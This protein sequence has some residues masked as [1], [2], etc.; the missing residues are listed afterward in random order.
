MKKTIELTGQIFQTL[1][2]LA[3]YCS[4]QS[5]WKDYLDQLKDNV[6]L[7]SFGLSEEAADEWESFSDIPEEIRA[8]A[9]Q[10]IFYHAIKAHQFLEEVNL[11]QHK[12]AKL[13]GDPICLS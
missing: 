13:T 12:K 7:E 1:V 11:L 10:T 5:E 9:P 8:E 3:K 6:N 2:E 4:D